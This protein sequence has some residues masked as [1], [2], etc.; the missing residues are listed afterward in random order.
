VGAL[1]GKVACRIVFGK[2]SSPR[3]L[4]VE[5]ALP[6]AP[7]PAALIT[8][9][10]IKGGGLK[11]LPET[12]PP[13]PPLHMVLPTSTSWIA[14]EQ[15]KATKK[16]EAIITAACAFGNSLTLPLVFMTG[17]LA[18]DELNQAAG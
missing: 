3:P 11:S 1:L 12:P 6:A 18:A 13:S 17:V 2:P 5:T 9:T 4:S 15:H 10:A 8:T 14:A 7:A 16:K